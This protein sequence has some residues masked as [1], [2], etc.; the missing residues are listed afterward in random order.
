MKGVLST[1]RACAGMPNALRPCR[2][3][4]LLSMQ[5]RWPQ[6]AHRHEEVSDYKCRVK[7]VKEVSATA[8]VIFS[9]PRLNHKAAERSDALGIGNDKLID[10]RGQDL[11]T[12]SPE[13]KRRSKFSLVVDAVSELDT[14]FSDSNSLDDVSAV[15]GL[16]AKPT[17]LQPTRS[18][19]HL[20]L[21]S[22][23]SSPTG[24]SARAADSPSRLKDSELRSVAA[25]TARRPSRQQRGRHIKSDSESESDTFFEVYRPSTGYR[26]DSRRDGNHT[27][28]GRRG[29]RPSGGPPAPTL[30][31]WVNKS[32]PKA[33]RPRD[34]GR[35]RRALRE[36]VA[37]ALAALHKWKMTN[38]A[39]T[40]SA[41]VR[42]ASSQGVEKERSLLDSD[43]SE[44]EGEEELEGLAE[45]GSEAVAEKAGSLRQVVE[46]VGKSLDKG[47][48]EDLMAELQRRHDWR[49]TIEVRKLYG[50]FG[51]VM[52]VVACWVP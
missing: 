3:D 52:R 18:S 48:V 32:A 7:K 50:S 47:E 28:A 9:D 49:T 22:L 8:A 29:D 39:M 42:G 35:P 10:L 46:E 36:N 31:V 15:G 13:T 24:F 40:R 1:P 11:S 44:T 20:D 25:S 2:D 21:D 43:S 23:L 4:S 38:R 5:G 30:P 51:R 12:G 14:R 19:R 41:S 6:H 37:A 17:A 27:G 45:A 33:P 34:D 16:L 26:R